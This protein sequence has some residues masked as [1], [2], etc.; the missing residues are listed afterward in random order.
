M[1]VWVPVGRD[2]TRVLEVRRDGARNLGR[3]GNRVLGVGQDEA[4]TQGVRR[5]GA[6]GLEIGRD[7]ARGL[8]VG[9][10]LLIRLEPSEEVSVGANILTLGIPNIDTRQI[11]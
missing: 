1:T 4:Y 9:R 10:D 5:D 8:G 3:D 7:G 11:L 6:R 2:R